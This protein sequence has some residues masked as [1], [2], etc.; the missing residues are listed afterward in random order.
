MFLLSYTTWFSYTSFLL[1]LSFFLSLISSPA[2]SSW[3]M[4]SLFSTC[5]S[6]SFSVFV[7]F[8]RDGG[9]RL[10]GSIFFP[11]ERFINFTHQFMST[12]YQNSA[13][14]LFMGTHSRHYWTHK[15]NYYSRFNI[16][17]YTCCTTVTYACSMKV[18]RTGMFCTS[19]ICILYDC[20]DNM[21]ISSFCSTPVTNRL[22]NEHEI[23]HAQL[24]S[25]EM[26][27]QRSTSALLHTS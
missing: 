17:R 23:H 2:L 11:F 6:L 14:E 22:V 19:D 12:H 5:P 4:N 8:I 25:T 3:V 27:F 24:W 26:H 13:Y 16:V 9:L 20:W 21:R 18:G 10:C 15:H 1:L 7:S